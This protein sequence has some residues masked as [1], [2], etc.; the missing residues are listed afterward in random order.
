[1]K[2]F[3][4]LL[5]ILTTSCRPSSKSYAD[6][7]EMFKDYVQRDLESTEFYPVVYLG[8]ENFILSNDGEVFRTDYIVYFDDPNGRQEAVE[9]HV[10]FK[11][12]DSDSLDIRSYKLIEQLP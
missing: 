5:L 9:M 10:K 11:Q 1:M 8:A 7:T 12:I 3:L 2:Y 4:I 6:R